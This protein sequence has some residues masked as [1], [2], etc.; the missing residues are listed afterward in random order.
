MVANFLARCAVYDMVVKVSPFMNFT[1]Y[2]TSCVL[3]KSLLQLISPLLLLTSL[4][5]CR[6][7]QV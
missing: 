1:V 6:L 2:M 5:L 3:E 7:V 4:R